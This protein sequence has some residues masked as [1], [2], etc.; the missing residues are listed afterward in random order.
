MLL[1]ERFFPHPFGNSSGRISASPRHIVGGLSALVRN[2]VVLDATLKAIQGA[3]KVAPAAAA[4]GTQA[5]EKD[6]EDESVKPDDGVA[7]NAEQNTS[8]WHHIKT[9]DGARHLIHPEDLP[10]AKRR[11]PRLQ[12]LRR[13]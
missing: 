10:E 5:I 9:S 2:P 4:A 13:V 8:D 1:N 11:D 3:Q 12:V 6:G 7:S